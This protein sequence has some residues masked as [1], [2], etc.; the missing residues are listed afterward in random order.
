MN[1]YGE[2]SRAEGHDYE[3]VVADN[4][5]QC[6]LLS[7]VISNE[8][9]SGILDSKTT[10]KSDVN[11]RERLGLSVKNPQKS[12]SSI[13]MMIMPQRSMIKFLNPTDEVTKYVKL[14]FGGKHFEQVCNDVGVHYNSLD[15]DQEARRS[16]CLHTSIPGN[17][18]GAFLEYMNRDNIKKLIVTTVLKKGFCSEETHWADKMLWSDS[19]EEGGKS[20]TK[21][22]YLC[23]IEELIENIC[24]NEWIIR[25]SNSVWEL[26]PL[27]LQMKGSGKKRGSSY[28]SLQFN[29]SLNDLR[30]KC[31]NMENF[32][33]GSCS[34]I[35]SYLKEII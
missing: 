8:K 7:R 6:G 13:Q 9:V 1:N 17:I 20:N 18:Q 24:E 25:D 3:D 11:I 12:S 33:N 10:A 26:G 22:V 21:H 15:F 30:N 5:N 35:A 16:R 27:T 23:D 34:E 2:K 28:H 29:M 19:S 14:F 31:E 4:F 32:V